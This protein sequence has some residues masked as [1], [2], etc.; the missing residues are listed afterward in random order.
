MFSELSAVA[1]LATQR[2]SRTMSLKSISY[3]VSSQLFLASLALGEQ[4]YYSSIGTDMSTDRSF[5]VLGFLPPPDADFVILVARAVEVA[6]KSDH[7]LTVEVCRRGIDKLPDYWL[8]LV[9]REVQRYIYT[10]PYLR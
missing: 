4:I 9:S 6:C 8:E 5:G 2:F 7:G 1:L 3:Q 10:R